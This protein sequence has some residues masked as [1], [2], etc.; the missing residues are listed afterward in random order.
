LASGS[1]FGVVVVDLDGDRR[2]DLI[3]WHDDPAQ[4]IAYLSNGDGTFRAS[5]T[6]LNA[7]STIN[8][9]HGSGTYDMLLGDFTGKGFTEILRVSSTAAT[10]PSFDQ[11]N[12]LLVSGSS[13]NPEEE[14][15]T[16]RQIVSSSGLT[17]TFT[18]QRLTTA[19]GGRYRNDRGTADSATGTKVDF[20]PAV[21]VVVTVESM[22]GVGS[23]TVTT[24]FAY[25]GLKLDTAGRGMVGFREFRREGKAPNGQPIT[26]VIQHSQDFPY[27]GSPLLTRSYLGPLLDDTIAPLTLSTVTYC[28]TSSTSTPPTALPNAIVLPCLSYSSDTSPVIYRPY[29]RQRLERA[30]DLARGSGDAPLTTTTSTFSYDSFGNAL[31]ISSQT[32]GTS[33]G[34]QQ[35]HT[36]TTTNT[37]FAPNTAGDNW[38]LGRLQ[39]IAVTNTVPNAMPTTAAG[40]APY[41]SARVGSGPTPTPAQLPPGVLQVI[42]QMILDTD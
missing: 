24:E 27:T 1:N 14:A 21:P 35:T 30:W 15:D 42:L 16:L 13:A 8:I 17:T 6:A 39:S 38:I 40:T 23:T 18:R 11:R 31:S 4:N 32:A 22:T 34:I 25:R 41:A 37:Y 7:I 12:L 2:H 26:T 5:T 20:L 10:A 19:A 36:Q 33:V 9:K 3:R 29:A 28:D